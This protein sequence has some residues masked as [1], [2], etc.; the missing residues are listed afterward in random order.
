MYHTST[1]DI[2][3]V[4][5]FSRPVD[6]SWG[7]CSRARTVNQKSTAPRR[8]R[9]NVG[10][11]RRGLGVRA[12]G[13]VTLPRR[14]ESCSASMAHFHLTIALLCKPA[15]QR[16]FRSEKYLSPQTVFAM[17]PCWLTAD[18]NWRGFRRIRLSV[19]AHRA[20][21]RPIDDPHC[22]RRRESSAKNRYRK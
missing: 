1:R 10:S 11:A 5:E 15:V 16:E 9:E 2:G 22:I 21:P 13:R 4:G 18:R 19:S 7:G 14:R 17:R 12:A 8:N 20:V 3:Q 6:R